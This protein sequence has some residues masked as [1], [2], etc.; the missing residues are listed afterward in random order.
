M[1][2][3]H[4]TRIHLR[5]RHQREQ[6]GTLRI[7]E[8]VQ[9]TLQ[10]IACVASLLSDVGDY[11]QCHQ[12]EILLNLARSS[13]P[14]VHEFGQLVCASD[15]RQLPKRMRLGQ[16]LGVHDRSGLRQNIRQIVMI[17][18]DNVNSAPPRVLDRLDRGDTRIACQHETGPRVDHL[19]QPFD[20]DA[21][22]L[23]LAHGDMEDN[24]CTQVA[25]G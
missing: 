18:D 16:H 9:T 21:V 20:V 4:P 25:Q 22:G 15:T 17:R 12:I 2:L 1:F 19:V 11:P 10:Q 14:I 13:G 5:R 7:P 8:N 3:A 23:F 24:V 6:A